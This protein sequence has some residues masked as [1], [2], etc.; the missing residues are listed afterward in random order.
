MIRIMWAKRRLVEHLHLRIWK[1][2]HNSDGIQGTRYF[3]ISNGNNSFRY[4]QTYFIF[5]VFT[6]GCECKHSIHSP[7]RKGSLVYKCRE[8][9]W[10]LQWKSNFPYK[11]KHRRRVFF[12][13]CVPGCDRYLS[14]LDGHDICL[15]CL[16]RAHA[17]WDSI[18][19]W[20]H[21][22]IVKTLSFQVRE[23]ESL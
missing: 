9:P 7:L 14:S 4:S 15:T 13:L 22:F 19:G 23:R 18:C 21:V 5:Y 3:I 17:G 2:H 6:N 8:L 12:R 1:T 16:S 20:F 11:R 10:P